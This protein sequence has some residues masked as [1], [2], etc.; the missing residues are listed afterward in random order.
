[1]TQVS[2]TKTSVLCKTEEQAVKETTS[3]AKVNNGEKLYMQTDDGVKN[4]EKP[5]THTESKGKE[6]HDKNV[7]KRKQLLKEFEK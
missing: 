6:L 7:K 2:H 4:G 3:F 5:M 1:M